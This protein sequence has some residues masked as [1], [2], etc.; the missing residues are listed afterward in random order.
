MRIP[1]PV[2][3]CLTG[4]F[5]GPHCTDMKA[6]TWVNNR[7][8]FD[9]GEVK[10]WR[11]A[12][13]RWWLNWSDEPCCTCGSPRDGATIPAAPAPTPVEPA[14]PRHRISIRRPRPP[15]VRFVALRAA[16]YL[17]SLRTTCR[18]VTLLLANTTQ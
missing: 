2:I 6:F 8:I 1:I 5:G 11:C 18:T 4:V 17:Q 15:I 16:S 7:E 14:K 9:N 10:K 13:C 3:N 12:D